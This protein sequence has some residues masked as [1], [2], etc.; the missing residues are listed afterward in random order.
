MIS[1]FSLPPIAI[2]D[3]D[4]DD[5]FLLQSRL[6][7]GGVRNPVLVF[8]GVREAQVYLQR[9]F[10][11]RDAEAPRPAVLFLD[12]KLVGDSGYDLLKWIRASD[13]FRDLS[14]VVISGLPETQSAEK[15]F[16]LGADRVL[17]KHPPPDLL[18]QIVATPRVV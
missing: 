15:A 6:A 14:V 8:P 11:E 16:E 10:V 7:R 13:V 12:L 17:L 18:A 1:L 3:D 4:P 9:A 5:V 2:V